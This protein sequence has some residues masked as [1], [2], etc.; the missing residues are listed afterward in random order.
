MS[1]SPRLEDVAI[2]RVGDDVRIRG[3][4]PQSWRR[5]AGFRSE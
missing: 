3:R 1:E 5:R 2:D 4:L